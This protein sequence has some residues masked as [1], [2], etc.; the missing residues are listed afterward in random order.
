MKTIEIIVAPDGNT[1]AETFG[2]SGQSCRE[3]SRFIESALG[4]ATNETL[5]PEFHQ[6]TGSQQQST[7]Q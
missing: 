3:A 1:R 6:A 2:F 7:R 5:K 4:K